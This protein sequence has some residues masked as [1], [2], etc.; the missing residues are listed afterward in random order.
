MDPCAKSNLLAHAAHHNRE[1]Y[2]KSSKRKLDT[3][4]LHTAVSI[5]P[6][7]ARLLRERAT[8]LLHN[9]GG[10]VSTRSA[11]ISH[12]FAFRERR[13]ETADIRVSSAIRVHELLPRKLQD[14]VLRN[15]T[16]DADDSVV[17]SL[18]DHDGTLASL[19]AGDERKANSDETDVGRVPALSLG[20]SER[21]R[22][23]AKKKVHVRHR[24]YK[25]RLERWHLHEERGGKVHAVNISRVCLLPR[26]Q[27]NRIWG[28]GDEETCAVD[29]PCPLDDFQVLGLLR[30]V[31]FVIV[32]RIQVRAQRPLDANNKRGT[33]PR[34]R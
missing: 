34:R 7:E 9:D 10:C 14:G 11:A 29:D 2:V 6:H 21:L 15:V 19:G 17:G 30:V 16:V 24:V 18:R 8:A 28:H 26:G 3:I 33:K 22:L 27:L 12:G 23:V 5:L 32:R 13:E 31:N 25:A 20:P 1:K 4:R